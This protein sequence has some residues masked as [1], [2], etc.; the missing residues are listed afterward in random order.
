MNGAI[1][2]LGFRDEVTLVLCSIYFRF[3]LL[4]RS[5]SGLFFDVLPLFKIVKNVSKSVNHAVISKL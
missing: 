5:V 2:F 4:T 1:M 3:M